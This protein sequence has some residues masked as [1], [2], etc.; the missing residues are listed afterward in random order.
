LNSEHHNI[1]SSK[2]TG[3]RKRMKLNKLPAGQEHDYGRSTPPIARP[4]VVRLHATIQP[5][6][7]RAMDLCHLSPR[8]AP[9][10]HAPTGGTPA[11][12]RILSRSRH[13]SLSMSRPPWGRLNVLNPGSTMQ[14]WVF[15]FI[16]FIV[17]RA[18]SKYQ[19]IGTPG[20]QHNGTPGPRQQ[21][22][23]VLDEGGWLCTACGETKPYTTMWYNWKGQLISPLI[24]H[25]IF[26]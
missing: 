13:S 17:K 2:L 16:F 6:D 19:P 22:D 15:L 12:P 11:S 18:S 10:W 26:D 3:C 9:R 24:V 21:L 8:P 4:I 20:R 25:L 23:Y 14:F 5:M 1:E 7:A